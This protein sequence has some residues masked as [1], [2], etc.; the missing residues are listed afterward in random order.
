MAKTR[1]LEMLNAEVGEQVVSE[2][3]FL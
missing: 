2:V 3:V 1:V